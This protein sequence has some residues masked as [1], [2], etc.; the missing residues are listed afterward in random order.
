MVLM[1]LPGFGLNYIPHTN[2]NRV[3]AQPEVC[4]P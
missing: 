1:Q 3:Y 4:Y 2:L